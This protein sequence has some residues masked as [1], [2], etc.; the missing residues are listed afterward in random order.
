M[1]FTTPLIPGTLIRRYKRF[2]ADIR[3]E[4]GR[5]LTVHCPNTGRMLRC[6]E[7]GSAVALSLSEN[8]KRK[9][10]HTLEMV[11]DGAHWVGVNTSRTNKIVAE[12]ILQG[13][14]AEFVGVKRLKTEV[15]ISPKTRLDL[16]LFLKKTTTFVEIKNSS[17]ARDN[18]AMFPD[19]VTVR[20]TR[21]LHE[22]RRLSLDGVASCIFYLVQRMDANRFRPAVEIDPVY[23]GAL[24]EAFD[25]GV[26][27]LVYQ[28]EVSPIGIE[29]VRS[30]PF[31]VA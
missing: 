27:V 28:A 15:K 19:A 16:Q 11:K 5:E 4:D 10:P 1:K 8:K 9:Y 31:E 17:L 23:S 20:G 13:Q 29:V 3:L 18:C 7:P 24:K 14:V 25:A 22:L 21:H 30:L 12:A 6:S 2:L 26:M